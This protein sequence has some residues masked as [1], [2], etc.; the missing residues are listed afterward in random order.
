MKS[1]PDKH[2]VPLLLLT[3][4]GA[5]LSRM[6]VDFCAITSHHNLVSQTLVAS[7]SA[8]GD[9]WHSIGGSGR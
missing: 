6:S 1:M 2:L 3:G 9:G 7:N 5:W 4:D 8:S